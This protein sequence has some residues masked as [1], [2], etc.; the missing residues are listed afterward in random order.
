MIFWRIS[1][2]VIIESVQI[3]GHITVLVLIGGIGYCAFIYSISTAQA[4]Q[5]SHILKGWL[6]Q[7]LKFVQKIQLVQILQS[8]HHLRGWSQ[9]KKMQF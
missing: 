2:T 5:K 8:F 9:N 3:T 6:M 4:I 1:A 7:F